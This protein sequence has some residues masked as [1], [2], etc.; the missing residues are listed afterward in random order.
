[1]LVPRPLNY[2]LSDAVSA[3]YAPRNCG[4]SVSRANWAREALGTPSSS[5]APRHRSDAGKC[6][7]AESFTGA[8]ALVANLQRQQCL[9]I[10]SRRR[11]T[12]ASVSGPAGMLAAHGTLSRSLAVYHRDQMQANAVS[13]RAAWVLLPRPL[14][15]RLSDAASTHVAPGNGGASVS[16]VVV[17]YEASGTLSSSF[18]LRD[19]AWML[20]NTSHREQRCCGR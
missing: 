13:Q 16:G 20:A 11:K 6:C 5:L 12:S 18:A 2:R 4:A 7:V 10:G 8:D 17:V 3:H 9:S 15:Y 1:M 14:N 19:C